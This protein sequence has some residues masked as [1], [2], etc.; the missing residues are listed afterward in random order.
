LKHVHFILKIAFPHCSV[1]DPLPT[2]ACYTETSYLPSSVSV[3]VQVQEKKVHP[4]QLRAVLRVAQCISLCAALVMLAYAGVS[5][6]YLFRINFA[7]TVS[8]VFGK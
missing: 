5:L 4:R 1:G 8:A 6:H 7:P 2:G 3:L